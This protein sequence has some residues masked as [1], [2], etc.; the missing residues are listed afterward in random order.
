MPDK[1]NIQLTCKSVS[2]EAV[3]NMVQV[4]LDTA[5]I[6]NILGKIKIT[7]IQQYL[8]HQ[9]AKIPVPATA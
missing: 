8:R 9:G 3:E 5:S 1:V 7:D 6:E 4:T 2:I